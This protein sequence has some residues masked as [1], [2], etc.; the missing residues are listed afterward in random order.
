LAGR[1]LLEYRIRQALQKA[2]KTIPD[3]KGKATSNPTARW[4]FQLFVGIHV[5]KIPDGQSVVLNLKSV[6]RDILELLSY[7]NFYS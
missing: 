1:I 2:E 3:Q 7:Q 6:H 5:L 4:V